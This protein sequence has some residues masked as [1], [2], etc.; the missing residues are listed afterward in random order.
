[1]KLFR[2]QVHDLRRPELQEL[3]Q[4]MQ[5]ETKTVTTTM[6]AQ[7]VDFDRLHRVGEAMGEVAKGVDGL[8]DTFDNEDIG[9]IGDGLG[10][11]ASYLD[12]QVSPTAGKAAT[13]LEETTAGLSED[14]K[15]L[16]ELLRQAPPDLKAAREIYDGLVRFGDGLEKVQD[17][18]KVERLGTMREGFQGLQSSLDSGAGQVDQLASYYYPVVTFNGWRPHIE[19]RK[20]WPEGDKIADGL[21]KAANGAKAADE[22]LAALESDL[23]K[24]RDSLDEARKMTERTRGAMALAMKQQDKI[25][26][27]LKDI[28][29]RTAKMAEELPKLTADLTHILRETEKLKEVGT[30]LRQAQKAVNMA[31]SKWPEMKTNLSKAST[32]LRATQ[33]QIE[34]A[35]A[36]RKEY[37]AALSQSIVLADSFGTLLPIYL[38]SLDRQLEQQELGLNDLGHGLDEVT[39][40]IPAYAKATNGLVQTGRLL[41]W[42]VAGIVLLHAGYLLISLRMGKAFS[43]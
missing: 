7:N 1:V 28:P 40:S 27:L 11:A 18:L 10:V 30:M 20:F 21:R 42:L 2:Q 24:L 3:G 37:E 6:K 9:K 15:K 36:R 16:A 22:Q 39:T 13:R 12:E 5:T 8:N 26:F 43:I 33:T 34:E 29:E 35:V 41:A 23:P 32:L 17:L 38:E 14:A 25:E 19:D 4:Q 31:V